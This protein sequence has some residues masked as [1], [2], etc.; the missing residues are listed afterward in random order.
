MFAYSD[1]MALSPKFTKAAIE[2]G[3]Y[4]SSI[5]NCQT[6][7]HVCGQTHTGSLKHSVLILRD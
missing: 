1:A 6:V 3:R 5:S 2:T 4:S 7:V